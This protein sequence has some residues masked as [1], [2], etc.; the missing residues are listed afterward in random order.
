[1]QADLD[2]YVSGLLAHA[3]NVEDKVEINHMAE[4]IINAQDA[5]SVEDMLLNQNPSDFESRL[6]IKRM[7][8]LAVGTC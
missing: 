3:A 8:S 2:N 4:D 1:M 5:E 7:G 6:L